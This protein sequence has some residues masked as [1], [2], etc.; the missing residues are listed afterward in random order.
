MRTLYPAH[1]LKRTKIVATLGPASS[2]SN[3]HEKLIRSGLNVARLNFSHGTHESHL[4]NLKSIRALA[5]KMNKPVAILQD[6]QGPKIRL[7]TLSEDQIILTKGQEITLFY[8]QTQIDKRIPVQY[9]IFPYL[10]VGDRVLINDGLTRLSVTK[11]D[12]DKNEAVCEVKIPNPI[13]SKKGVNLPDSKLPSISLT[14]KDKIDLKFGLSQKVDYIAL[15]FVQDVD[16]IDTLRRLINKSDYA[17]KIIA[18][19]ETREAIKNL[20]RI[21]VA[22]DAVMVARGD[23]AVEMDPEDVPLIQRQIVT[24]CRKHHTPVIVATQMLESMVMNSEPTRAEV[25]DVAT[26]VLDNVDAIMLSAESASGAYPIE[27]VSMMKRIIRRVERHS[28]DLITDYA[29]AAL[30]E[31]T[32]QTTAIA[33]AASILAHQI[34][35]EIIVVATTSGR[36]AARVASYRPPTP[37]VAITDDPITYNQLALLWG[38]KAFY[39]KTP[40][41]STDTLNHI[42]KEIKRRGYVNK[43]DKIIYLTGQTPHKIG[44]TNSIKVEVIG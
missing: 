32:D 26:A 39:H 31:S 36:T 10:S 30:E 16:D 17:P 5:Q 28:H 37:I 14:K 15:S 25:N 3:I 41:D 24:L 27:A 33:A 2:T 7:G 23:L 38:V 44:G 29:L 21:I 40:M 34:K 6:L 11:I 22:S 1:S 9:N 43:S 42:V 12:T 4:A 13:K 18:K 19:I 35:A 20:E 8:G